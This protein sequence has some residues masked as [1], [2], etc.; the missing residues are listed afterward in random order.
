MSEQAGKRVAHATAIGDSGDAKYVQRIQCGRHSLL[1]DEPP[2]GGGKDAGPSP[3]DYVTC[4]LGACTA[5]TL[6]MYAERKG[7]QLGIVTVDVGLWRD[8]G[9]SRIERRVS[10]S[11]RL[12]ETQRARLADICERTPVTLLLKRGIEVST[13]LVAG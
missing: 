13:S 11:A 3:T 2:E 6:R 8:D 7:W 5:M 10:V 1:A 12:D 4:G 9:N